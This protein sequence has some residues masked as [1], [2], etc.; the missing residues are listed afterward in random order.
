MIAVWSV[1]VRMSVG[2]SLSTRLSIEISGTTFSSSHEWLLRTCPTMMK[3]ELVCSLLF[4]RC[5]DSVL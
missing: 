5:F 3:M 1:L 4:A 2:S